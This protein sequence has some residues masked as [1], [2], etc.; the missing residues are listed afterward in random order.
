MR[1]T[2]ACL[3]AVASVAFTFGNSSRADIAVGENVNMVTGWRMPGGDPYLQRQNEPSIA[4]SSVNPSHL[5]AGA[6]DYRTVDIPFPD[7]PS[8]AAGDAWAGVFKSL[9][10]GRTWQ[11]TLLPGYPQDTSAGGAASPLRTCRTDPPPPGTTAPVP[12]KCVAAADP[13]VRAGTDGLFYYAGLAFTRD[14]LA[15]KIY[16]ARF[17]DGNDK[18]N[19]DTG[20]DLGPTDPIRYKGASV[21]ASGAATSSPFCPP[22]AATGQLVFLDKPWI[23]VDVPRGWG[24]C[25]L[26]GK[27]AGAVYAVWSAY[28]VSRVCGTEQDTELSSDIM[29]S[30]S[31][32]C[33]ATWSAP[34]KISTKNSTLNQGASIAIEPITGRVYVAWRRVASGTQGDAIMATRSFGRKKQFSNPRVVTKSIVPFDQGAADTRI[35]TQTMPSLAIS[36]DGT[37]SWAHVAW[38]QRAGPGADARIVISSAAIHPPP[39]GDQDDD[40]DEGYEDETRVSWGPPLAADGGDVVDGAGNHYARGHQFMPS[41]TFG[42]GRLV[43][44]W[45]D[46]RLDHTRTLYT[47]NLTFDP[48]TQTTQWVLLGGSYYTEQRRPAGSRDPLSP[49]FTSF[50][51]STAAAKN[52]VT[53]FDYFDDSL[54]RLNVQQFPNVQELRRTVD[55]RIA[56]SPPGGSPSFRSANVTSYGIGFMNALFFADQSPA[57]LQQLGAN[58]PNLPMFK[59]GTAGFLGDYIDVQGPAFVQNGNAWAFNHAPT[60]APVFHAIWTTNQNVRPPANGDWTKYTP[61]NLQGQTQSYYDPTAPTNFCDDPTAGNEGTRNQDIYTSRIS[62]GLVVTSPQ[63]AKPIVDDSRLPDGST[64]PPTT[65]VIGAQNATRYA[66]V[67]RFSLSAVPAGV[68]ASFSSASDQP[69]V[70]VG[71]P[72]GSSAARTVFARTAAGG[73]PLSSFAAWVTETGACGGAGQAPCLSGSVTINPPGTVSSTIPPDGCITSGTAACDIALGE[74]WGVAWGSSG[75]FDANGSV[76]VMPSPSPTIRDPGSQVPGSQ[77]PGSQVPGSQVPGSQVPGSQVPGSQVPGSQVPGSQVLTVENAAVMNP[78]SQVPGSQVPGSQVP[79][80]QVVSFLNPGSQ[81]PGSQVPGS[82]VPGSQVPGSQVPGSQV[83]GSQVP[84]SQVTAMSDYSV[85]L[86]NTGNTGQSV[87][88]QL[89]NLDPATPLPYLQMLVTKFYYTPWA[90]SCRL[91][92]APH[93]LTEVNVPFVSEAAVDP[94]ALATPGT[95]DARTTNVT[96]SLAPGEKKTITVR[97]FMPLDQMATLSTKL[98]VVAVPHGGLQGSPTYIDVIASRKATQTVLQYDAANGGFFASVTPK[99]A[100]GA[101]TFVVDGAEVGVQPLNTDTNAW[102]PFTP[103]NGQKAVAFYAGDATN[104]PSVSNEVTVT[105]GIRTVTSIATDPTVWTR[106]TPI[107]IQAQVGSG[108]PAVTDLTPLALLGGTVA[109]DVDG[110]TTV[111]PF[112]PGTL[113]AYVT[114]PPL[115]SGP[116]TIQAHFLGVSTATGGYLPSDSAVLSQTV[117]TTRVFSAGANNQTV[118]RG[119]ATDSAG[120]AYVVGYTYGALP[121][122]TYN[123]GADAFVAKLDPSGTVQWIRQFGGGFD[124]Y[125]V[126]VATDRDGNV[127]VLGA[128]NGGLFVPWKTLGTMDVFLAKYSTDGVQLANGYYVSTADKEPTGIAVDGSRGIAYVTGWSGSGMMLLASFETIQLRQLAGGVAP[129]PVP[130]SWQTYG[131]A[132]DDRSGSVYLSGNQVASGGGNNGLLAAFTSDLKYIWSVSQVGLGSPDSTR[133]RGVAVGANGDVYVSGV[134]D[135]ATLG[136]SPTAAYRSSNGALIWRTETPGD[137]TGYPQALAVAV[138]RAGNVFSAGTTSRSLDGLPTPTVGAA[139]LI[140]YDGTTGTP[141]ALSELRAG[142]DSGVMGVAVDPSGNVW[143]V[144]ACTDGSIDG[145]ACQ[146]GVYDALVLKYDSN[147]VRQ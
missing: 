40:E 133:L 7:A 85:D 68:T 76:G 24:T 87:R 27:P 107:T 67:F 94:T 81:V 52:T 58:P 90:Q 98:A 61:I 115:S 97:G 105:N 56:M 113:R 6:N 145:V 38:A 125:A 41:L 75:L 10:G 138:D 109:F 88:V 35:R 11:S 116:H 139:Y 102:L 14:S 16:V 50:F 95:D 36:S 25:A 19:G 64:F 132:S 80:S 119:V 46:S 39:A 23:A 99:A 48:V 72:P 59:K 137:S 70:D 33:G 130:G 63:N 129:P 8:K 142:S 15:S 146:P 128:S 43:L 57:Q 127:Y 89:V 83:P 114:I 108:D 74:I 122:N 112:S 141:L 28:R 13:V 54:P 134:D 78:G 20:A 34:A 147:L 47:P 1:T 49:G 120:N 140:K 136:S 124:D 71:I 117:S 118:A 3:A 111:I 93:G 73:Y 45:Y 30:Q 101:V 18:E 37:S 60:G 12:V 69:F 121:G 110:V 91:F 100:T 126:A 103:R 66:K 51:T 44:V 29:F 86:Y 2:R 144:G 31:L 32:D 92:A 53:G 62:E 96:V 104:Q 77:V 9:D 65:F 135:G 143:A 26:T 5:L 79:G 42:Q 4:I 131:I 82:Q 22:G 17:L 55:V 123:G 106:G 21:L 84:G